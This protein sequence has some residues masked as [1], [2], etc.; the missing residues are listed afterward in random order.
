MRPLTVRVG[1]ICLWTVN[2]I[3]LAVTL[4]AFAFSDVGVDWDVYT[5]A[6]RRFFTEGLYEWDGLPWRYS[7]VLAP[8]FVLLAPIG[9]L[10]W[11]LLHFAALLTLPRNVA[12]LALVSAPFWNDVYNGNTMTFVFVAAWHALSGSRT[13]T[14]SFLALALLIPRP[15]M[16][17]VL[18]W[19]LWNQRGCIAPFV[20]MF[21]VHAVAVLMTGWGTAWIAGEVGNLGRDIVSDLSPTNLIGVWWYPIAITLSAWMTWRGWLGPASFLAT[22]YWSLHYGL[23][24]LI[25][26]RP[27]MRWTPASTDSG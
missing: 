9:Y 8:A 2:A 7:P 11:S 19:L 25:P 10:G 20:G 14:Y 1:L 22:G 6:G 12:L 17:P 4:A 24:F 3:L 16:L 23:M 27:P 5:E 18:A 15:V 26:N 13:G 21:G